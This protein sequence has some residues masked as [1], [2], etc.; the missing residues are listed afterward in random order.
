MI[1][2]F[3]SSTNLSKSKLSDILSVYYCNN[4]EKRFKLDESEGFVPLFPQKTTV[5]EPPLEI[6]SRIYIDNKEHEFFLEH[7]IIVQK[8]YLHYRILFVSL[9]NKI[10]NRKLWVPEHWVKP[11]P[12]EL[13][14]N[15]TSTNQ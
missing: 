10:N 12:K 3:C 13:T 9:D 7:G 8:G 5:D 4:C 14:D 6:A 15:Y 2:P 1:C 11:L